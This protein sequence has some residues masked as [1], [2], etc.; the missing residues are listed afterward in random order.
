MTENE[1]T[2]Q[3]LQ[4]GLSK[5]YYFDMLVVNYHVVNDR[6]NIDKKILNTKHLL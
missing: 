6:S 3:N 1:N 4:N 2:E 5:D